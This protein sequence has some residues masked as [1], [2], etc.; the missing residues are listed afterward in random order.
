MNYLSIEQSKVPE[1]VENLNKILANYQ[2][3]YQKLRAFHWNVNGKHFFELHMKFEELYKDAILKI[4][5][6]AERILTLQQQPV[7]TLKQ[8]L[9]ISTIKE[10]HDFSSELKMVEEVVNDFNLLLSMERACMKLTSNA[11]DEGTTEM[12]SRFI[13]HKE[14]LSWM[15]F[16]WLKN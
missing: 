5:E 9:E 6:V 15:F 2:I 7:S 8:Y 16:A 3:H 12:L 14:K 11:D 1:I 10:V 4:D 13:A